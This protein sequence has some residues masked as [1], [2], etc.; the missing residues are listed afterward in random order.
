METE[1]ERTQ[2][3]ENTLLK[4]TLEILLVFLPA[5]VLIQVMGP[6]AGEDPIRGMSVIWVANV[7]ML[8]MVW[9][10]MKKSKRSWKHLG[11]TFNRVSPVRALRTFAWS[12]LVF[13]S[14]VAGFILGP[15]LLSAFMEMPESADFTRYEFLKDNPWGLVISLLGVYFVSSFGEEV[16]YR[17]FLIDRISAMTRNTRFSVVTTVF[18]SS[19]FFAFAHY[20]WGWLG[21]IQTGMMGLVLA[22]F[23]IKLKKRLWILIIAHAYMDT[24]LL[25]QLYLASN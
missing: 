17:A 13:V 22:I 5:L 14:A 11:L 7:L 1:I 12:L 8:V 24:L 19:V 18:L 16:V 25:V 2:V 20:E 9:F 23:Y 6:W 10:V 3:G 4:G 15:V 21:I